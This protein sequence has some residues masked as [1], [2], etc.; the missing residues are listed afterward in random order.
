M[1]MIDEEKARQRA[2]YATDISS[3]ESTDE[4]LHNSDSEYD[5]D[6]ILAQRVYD[7]DDEPVV[8]YLVKYTDYPLHR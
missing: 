5:A 4:S 7:D 8:Q 2:A 1:G 3:L 6:D